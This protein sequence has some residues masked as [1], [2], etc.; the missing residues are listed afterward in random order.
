MSCLVCNLKFSSLHQLKIPI[1]M[2]NSSRYDL[3]FIVRMLH[4]VTMKFSIIPK[5]TEQ[6]IALTLGSFI[7]LDS[8]QHLG[9]SL[10]VLAKN[11]KEKGKECFVHTLKHTD[12]ANYELLLRK[13]VFCYTYFDNFCKF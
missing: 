12:S 1:I 2:H 3:H 13:G 10:S 7:F 6:Y 4:K 9:E 11:L 5:D 8:F